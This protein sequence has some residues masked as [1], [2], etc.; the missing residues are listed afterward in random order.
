MTQLCSA[1][2]AEF[3]SGDVVGLSC[4]VA[5]EANRPNRETHGVT[6]GFLHFRV[7]FL[8][9]SGSD[10]RRFLADFES[11]ASAIPPPRHNGDYTRAETRESSP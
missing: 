5:S 7:G 10:R 11:A 6:V 9:V 3:M 4:D 8:K 1:G 2:G